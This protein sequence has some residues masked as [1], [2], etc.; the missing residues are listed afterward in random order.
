MS[1][2]RPAL[3][4]HLNTMLYFENLN[5]FGIPKDCAGRESNPRVLCSPESKGVDENLYCSGRT[6][7]R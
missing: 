2:D 6:F 3:T 1:T 7:S 4:G 5:R